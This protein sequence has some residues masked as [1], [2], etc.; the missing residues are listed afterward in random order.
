MPMTLKLTSSSIFCEQATITLTSQKKITQRDKE[1]IKE[2]IA[3]WKS[4]D[5]ISFS[6]R[7]EQPNLW[8]DLLHQITK[9]NP[10]VTLQNETGRVCVDSISNST[11]L[12][13]LHG[14]NLDLSF[15]P[16][17]LLKN[18]TEGIEKLH[19]H[20]CT[21]D[22]ENL[23]FFAEKLK[24][25]ALTVV[26]LA[27][28]KDTAILVHHLPLSLQSL[29]L[30]VSQKIDLHNVSSLKN[31]TDLCLTNSQHLT[32]LPILPIVK[33]LDLSNCSD[34][35]SLLE[36]L[37]APNLKCLILR[38]N[39]HSQKDLTF[40]CHFLQKNTH[41]VELDLTDNWTSLSAT[42]VVEAFLKVVPLATNLLKLVLGRESSN[43]AKLSE[44]L[45]AKA[46]SRFY[47]TVK[48]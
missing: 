38:R 23:P 47:L 6:H 7:D 48:N 26:D 22:A 14:Q 29:S 41:L 40:I 25:S 33:K 11:N 18:S 43:M 10:N 42:D 5:T 2:T 21:F 32:S 45:N 8:A 44:L 13:L 31:L 20:A 19:L 16:L 17:R 36:S 39:F 24:N 37:N 3:D 1:V 46:V 27:D 12:T 4:V 9:F 34:T 35:H 15:L 28:L 30:V